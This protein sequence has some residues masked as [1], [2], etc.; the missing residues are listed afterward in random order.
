MF[1]DKVIYPE[2]SEAFFT[3]TISPVAGDNKKTQSSNS[4][5]VCFNLYSSSR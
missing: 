3:P 4:D 5:T 1:P 2:V